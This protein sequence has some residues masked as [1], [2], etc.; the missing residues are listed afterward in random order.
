MKQRLMRPAAALFPIAGIAGALLGNPSCTMVVF[1]SYYL[2]Q[3]FSLCAADCFRN[4]AAQEPG[5]R[6]VDIR[7]SGSFLP[8]AV[9]IVISWLLWSFALSPMWKIGAWQCPFAAAALILIEHMFEERMYAL[10]RRI[11]GVI[12]SCVANGLL[13]A[14]LVMGRGG[15]SQIQSAGIYAIIGAGI[16]AVMSIAASYAIEP[17][18]G[19]SL[20]PANIPFSKSA[21]PQ[22][23][24]YGAVAVIVT[25]ATK[26]RILDMLV[27]LLFGLIPWRLA[28]TTCRRAQD[29]TRALNLLLI[30][31]AAIATAASTLMSILQPYALTAYIALICSAIVF[32]APSERFFAGIAL[33]A[34]AFMMPPVIA[35]LLA[36]AAIAINANK[37]FLRKV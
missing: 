2:M 24:L 8:M 36:L 33:I 6:R 23:L 35:I 5:V 21:V 30:S 15:V 27:P 9:G 26:S 31:I 37:A 18:H 7:F 3:L 34:I 12:L 17:S 11:D 20:K 19:F 16:G 25:V 32:C 10:G 22:T 1:V 4:A 14:G 28:R 13:A 29:E